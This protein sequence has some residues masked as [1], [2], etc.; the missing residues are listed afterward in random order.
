VRRFLPVIVQHLGERLG[1]PD[2]FVELANDQQPRITGQPPRRILD[3]D[4]LS[5]QKIQTF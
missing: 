4:G 5:R 1:H 2:P 3:H